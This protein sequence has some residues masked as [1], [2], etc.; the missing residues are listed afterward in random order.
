M[1]QSIRDKL[2]HLTGRLEEL[3]RELSSEEGA[4]DMNAG[5]G[6]VPFLAPGRSR[7]RNR[8]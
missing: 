8:A 4:R 1:K 3:D 7:L 6:A 5:G 2:E